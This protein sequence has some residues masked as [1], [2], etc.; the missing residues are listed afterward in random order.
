M[1]T[2]GTRNAEELITDIRSLAY[3]EQYSNTEGWNNDTLV[4]ILNLGLA[5]L[6]LAVTKTDNPANIEQ[7]SFSSVAGQM[8]YDLPIDVL[9][10][11]RIMDVRYI[12]GAG[13]GYFITLIQSEIQDRMDL[14]YGNPTT[15]CIRNGQILFSPTP[16]A[17]ISNAFVI[18]YQKR[19]RN[20]DVRR[21]QVEDYT[22]PESGAMSFE[23]TFPTTSQKLARMQQAALLLDNVD[24]CCIVNR[25]GEPV[26]SEIPIDAYNYVSHVVTCAPDYAFS[27]E[28][29]DAL[30][31]YLDN[32]LPVYVVAG[33]YS[34][35]HSQLDM[36]TEQCLIE[37][38]VA[39]MLALESSSAAPAQQARSD[40]C[41]EN[42]IWAYRRYR[43]SAAPVEFTNRMSLRTY[44]RGAF[45]RF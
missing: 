27:Q 4:R 43:E 44:P 19:M 37:Y 25:D 10:G 21:G 29:Q 38:G 5:D 1:P 23:L 32:S 42:M 20:L 17:T 39:R 11:V 41:M 7:Y 6:T 9:M 31:A 22:I 14:P 30:D 35:T 12:W 40:K 45:S 8:A 16:S 15:Y 33:K 18:N 26:I 3:A 2:F 34:S 28:E 36:Q 13:P 24:Y